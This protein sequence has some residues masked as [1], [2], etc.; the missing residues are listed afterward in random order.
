[1][2]LWETAADR[3]KGIPTL[4][5]GDDG[6]TLG[7]CAQIFAGAVVSDPAIH[8]KRKNTICHDPFTVVFAGNVNMRTCGSSAFTGWI[9]DLVSCFQ[10][11]PKGCALSG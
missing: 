6:R 10:L 2:L 1:M 11:G 9:A 5:G 4:T 7:E 3:R 8:N